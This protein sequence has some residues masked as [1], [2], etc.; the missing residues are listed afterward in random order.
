M[1][2]SKS[3]IDYILVNK[4]LKNSVK[5]VEAYSSFASA[6]SN[7]RIV[8]ARLKLSLWNVKRLPEER[9]MIGKC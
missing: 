2:D 8:I 7:H 6:G 5:N 4:K 3:Q 9:S 1:T